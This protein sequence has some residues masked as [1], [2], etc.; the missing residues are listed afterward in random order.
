MQ[1]S[2]PV[3]VATNPLYAENVIYEEILSPKLTPTTQDDGE[4]GYVTISPKNAI[5][6]PAQLGESQNTV[7]RLCRSATEHKINSLS[8]IHN[9]YIR[10]WYRGRETLIIS[11]LN[12][13]LKYLQE[14]PADDHEAYVVMSSAGTLTGP[15]LYFT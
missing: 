8:P 15:W 2:G 14:N 9:C 7:V 11:N 3:A 10:D 4:R 6:S 1:S 5:S 13:D 12:E